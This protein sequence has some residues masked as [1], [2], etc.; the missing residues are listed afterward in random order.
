MPTAGVPD[1]GVST[2]VAVPVDVVVVPAV[3]ATRTRSA[4]TRRRA[5]A[6]GSAPRRVRSRRP[7]TQARSSTV[8]MPPSIDGII[9]TKTSDGESFRALAARAVGPPQGTMFM[10]PLATPAT[11]VRMTGES[12]RR[13]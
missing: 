1:G 9:G 10:T 13:R 7:S 4:P 6:N 3:A 11:A 12:P 5:S 2:V 8:A